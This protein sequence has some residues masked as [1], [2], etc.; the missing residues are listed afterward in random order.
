VQDACS[1]DGDGD[2]EWE[3]GDDGTVSVPMD[4]NKWDAERLVREV[5][6][7][8]FRYEVKR[9]GDE[10]RGGDEGE[11]RWENIF[12]EKRRRGG[13]TSSCLFGRGRV[14]GARVLYGVTQPCIMHTHI[15]GVFPPPAPPPLV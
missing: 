13:R 11:K 15:H 12:G 2:W 9:A 5:S 3:E 14:V 4:L 7:A 6:D 8:Q 1:S 10:G